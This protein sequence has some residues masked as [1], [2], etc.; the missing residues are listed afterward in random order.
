MMRTNALGQVAAM[1]VTKFWITPALTLKRS[2]EREITS[3]RNGKV[4]SHHHESC[5][6][7]VQYR[8]ESQQHPHP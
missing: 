7:C 1:P 3:E 2:V 6:A 4:I 8:Q 5:P